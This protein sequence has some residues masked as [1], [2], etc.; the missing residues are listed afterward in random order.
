MHAFTRI[1]TIC[2]ITAR[3]VLPFPLFFP[4]GL[5]VVLPQAEQSD[6][7]GYIRSAESLKVM[8]VKDQPLFV[9]LTK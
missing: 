2:F 9:I 7:S 3:D 1:D 6:D 8:L 5:P 4:G